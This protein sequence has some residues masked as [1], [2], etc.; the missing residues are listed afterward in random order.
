MK[1]GTILEKIDEKQLFIPAFQREY[2]WKREDAKQLIDSLVKE[3]PTGTM[4]TWETSHPP[5]LK[6]DH[7]YSAQQGAV[8]LLLD[9]QQ[10]IT[11]L[12]MLIRGEIPPYY[13]LPEI[14]NDTRG[15]YVNLKTLEL[16]YYMKSRMEN[17]PAWQNITDIF[18][19]SIDTFGLQDKF[20]EAGISTSMES[21]RELNEN[22]NKIRRVVDREFPEQIIPPKATIKEAIDIFYKVNASGVALT[23]AELALAQISGYWPQARDAF[24]A[25]LAELSAQG[26]VLKLDFLVYALLGCMYSLGSEMRKLH[27]EENL[28]PVYDESGNLVR[29]GI[30]E[31]WDILDKYTL[32]YVVNILRSKA[33]VDHTAEIN[34]V[35]ALIPIIVFCFDRYTEAIPEQQLRRLVKW[36]YYSQVR[37]RYISQLPQKLDFDIRII[38]ESDRPFEELLGVIA[39][40]KR[41][42]IQPD[43]F[44]GRSVSH[45]FFGMMKWYLKSQGAVCL[46]TGLGIHKPMGE[47]YQLEN[48]HIFPFSVLKKSGYGRE[49]RIK[50]SLAQEF[51]NRAILTQVANRRKSARLASDYLSE[52]KSTSPMALEKQ[53]IPTDEELWSIENYEEFLKARRELLATKINAYLEGLA[54]EHVEDY[55][56]ATIEE[57]LAEDENSELEF[58]SSLRWD[59][60]QGCVNKELEKIIVKAVAAFGNSPEGGTLLIGVNDERQALGLEN[61]YTSLNGDKD[62]FELHLRTLLAN[63]LGSAYVASGV[64]TTFPAVN[65]LE[66]CQVDIAPSKKPLIVDIKDKNGVASEKF[67]VRD[68]NKSKE[69]TRSEYEDYRIDRFD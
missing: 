56:R 65:G 66:I 46:T 47:K 6:G 60:Q 69:L 59:Y 26:F 37:A 27:G 9:G 42:E 61:D 3:Y 13:T 52:I 51:T 36:F 63:K 67:Y 17:N 54:V 48:D 49:N 62:K 50:Y 18:S 55:G 10:R 30:K 40:D 57:L 33:Y 32:D 41:L 24:K 45:P 43:E 14:V 53:C 1:I 21:L 58:K 44:T 64:K 20:A 28:E 15:L 11:T 4:L 39:E 25:K 34:S 68:G 23:E 29:L 38:R 35:Y 7:Q 2:V 16:S 31:T 8:K 19:G 12:Y 5:E 22:I